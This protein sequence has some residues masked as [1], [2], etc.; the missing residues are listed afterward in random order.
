EGPACPGS[1]LFS[2]PNCSG[3]IVGAEAFH[4]RVRDGNG[5][6]H[7]APAT[8]TNSGRG[9]RTPDLR[10]M[11]PTSCRCSIPRQLWRPT[12]CTGTL[13]RA[14][15][16]RSAEEYLLR[17]FAGWTRVPGSASMQVK[18]STI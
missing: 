6:A 2:T 11:S 16:F 12:Q 5:W 13:G 7:L 17:G 9:I 1:G 14:P 10:V 15:A 18:A 4:D 8:R 3:S